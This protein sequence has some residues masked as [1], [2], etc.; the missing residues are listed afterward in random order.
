[1]SNILFTGKVYYRFDELASTNDRASE[2]IA[3]SKPPEGTAL[4][5]DTQTAG[6]GQFG[7]RWHSPPGLNLLLS[8]IYYPE[9]L[10]AR[11]QFFLGMAVALGLKNG[12]EAAMAASGAAT[13]PA[14][15]IKWPNDLYLNGKKT[16]GTLI[17]NSLTGAHI[18]SS[19]IGIG[20]N[21]NQLD[22]DPALPNPTSLSLASGVLYDLDAVMSGLFEALEMQYLRL[23]NGEFTQIKSDYEDALFRKGEA[24]TFILTATQQSFRGVIAGVTETGFLRV[25]HDGRESTFDLK[26]VSL[27]G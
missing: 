11:K 7:S 18:E 20:L 13:L 9:W 8:V 12:V 2:M 24:A 17:Q 21:V 19:V 15:R 23:K 1:M 26:E 6:R 16:A 22:F 10:A 5:A 14:L 3:K 25:L 27:G 4:R